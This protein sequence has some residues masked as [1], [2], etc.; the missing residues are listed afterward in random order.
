M[1][2]SP[3]HPATHA[4][5]DAMIG[6]EVWSRDGN[7]VGLVDRIVHPATEPSDGQGGHVVVVRPDTEAGPL[8]HNT[9]F[10]PEEAIQAVTPAAVELSVED[11]E[12]LNQGWATLPLDLIPN[13][14]LE[15]PD[16]IR[17]PATA[18]GIRPE[19]ETRS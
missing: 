13:A 2:R 14:D 18:M 7:R 17:N 19:T 4:D 15:P 11:D 10:V 6:R 1:D 12:L 8:G 3:W 16:T 9:L 5:Y